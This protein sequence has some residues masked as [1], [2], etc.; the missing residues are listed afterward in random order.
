MARVAC[1]ALLVLAAGCASLPSSDTALDA[2]AIR[3]GVRA[4]LD[5]Q[6]AA[7]NAGSI[8]DFMDGYV[9]ADSLR[10]LSGGTARNGWEEAYYGYVRGY[11][12]TA[13]MGQ[14][15]FSDLD[16]TPLASDRALAWG[17]W[18]LQREGDAPGAGPG[19]LFTLVLVSTPEGWRV[20]HDH[21]SSE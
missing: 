20:A 21:T 8:R 16:I 6:Q 1:L 12:D 13:A 14:L 7:W 11:P 10:F 18:R 15:T 5:A 17:R 19:G 4:T 3:S 9:R 2:Q